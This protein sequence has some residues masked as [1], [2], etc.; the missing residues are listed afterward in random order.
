M[1]ISTVKSYNSLSSTQKPQ[2]I[3]F[4]GH[5]PPLKKFLGLLTKDVFVKSKDN[6]FCND[7][8]S[9]SGVKA[10]KFGTICDGSIK[11]PKFFDYF[12]KDLD[13]LS[14]VKERGQS[15]NIGAFANCFLKT[16][17]DNPVSTSGVFDCSVF[18]LFN[19]EKNTH[20][21]YHAFPDIS[22]PELKYMIKNFMKEGFSNAAIVPGN[23]NWFGIH[24]FSLPKIFN[25]IKSINP[26]CK[27]K[28]YHHSSMYPEIVGYKGN[29]F[30]IPNK[31]Y[32]KYKEDVPLEKQFFDGIRHKKTFG[33]A[34][35]DIRE[36]KNIDLYKIQSSCDIHSLINRK[37]EYAKNEVLDAEIKKV[38]QRLLNERI[39][40]IKKLQS[41]NTVE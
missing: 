29:L 28:V 21:M 10:G 26:N 5:L 7:I 38:F 27:T 9:I 19:N 3:S 12:G 18:Y 25:A 2:D 31:I 39:S 32:S 23:K 17:G 34:S 20:F 13:A 30:E 1:K 4:S 40:E 36:A 37:K 22:V 11:L 6:I 24:T 33:Q 16:A 8:T 15:T 14:R 35:F 41:F